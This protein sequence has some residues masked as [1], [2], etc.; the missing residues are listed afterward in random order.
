MR[1]LRAYT[2]D[3]RYLAVLGT[4]FGVFLLLELGFG[5]AAKVDPRRALS[6]C[7]SAYSIT[8]TLVLISSACFEAIDV[9]TLPDGDYAL[10][11]QHIRI[12]ALLIT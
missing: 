12:R 9:I 1:L 11:V 2:D 8:I 6:A 4:K 5:A 10:K 7:A 3:D